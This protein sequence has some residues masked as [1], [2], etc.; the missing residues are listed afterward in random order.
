MSQAR[1]QSS[2]CTSTSTRIS[3]GN[4]DRRVR[5]VELDGHLVGQLVPALVV[6]DEAPHDVLQRRADEEVLLPEP[7][8]TAARRAIVRI[9]HLRQV[10]RLVLLLDGLDV[11]PLVEVPKVE[12]LRRLGRPEPHVVDRARVVTRHR[13]V[14]G[15]RQD[16]LRVHPVE[17]QHALVVD[18]LD[19]APAELHRVEHLGTR[20]L[21]GVALP[22]PVVRILHLIAPLDPLVEHAV[23]VADAVAVARQRERR[24]R[25]EEAGGQAPEAAVAERGVQLHLVDPVEIELEVRQR[26]ATALV[27]PHVHQAVRQQAAG[28]ELHR[29]VVDPLGV[30]PVVAA[31]GLHPALDQSFAD[32]VGGRVEPVAGRGGERVLAERVDQAIRQRAPERFPIASERVVSEPVDVK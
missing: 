29:E 9:E 7:Q 28:Q 3:S 1:S 13:R 27:E 14:E 20:E 5:V 2:P 17:P 15:H 11:V 4:R 21:P 18:D 19:D 23:L 10:L 30:R 22:E 32:G 31:H 6:L 8:L 26:V 12:V 25:I 16:V 24:H